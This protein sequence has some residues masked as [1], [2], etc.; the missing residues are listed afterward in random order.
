VY[1]ALFN[2][3]SNGMIPV[4]LVFLV[5]DAG[6]TP[7]ELGLVLALATVG[8][9]AGGMLSARVSALLGTGRAVA[10]CAV[11]VAA[12][13]LLLAATPASRF[14]GPWVVV[15]M[16]VMWA[17]N[18]AWNA[19]VATLRQLLSPPAILGRLTAAYRLL[20]Y[21]LIPVGALTGGILGDRIGSRS[22]LVVLAG[23]IAVVTLLPL[24]RCV[25]ELRDPAQDEPAE[26]DDE[27]L[28]HPEPGQSLV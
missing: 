6:L 25:R 20:A 2:G 23:L 10:A 21:V 12:G 15:V 24:G 1:T 11:V 13:E 14:A 19:Q 26:R 18:T 3:A 8:A 16:G 27:P 28:V 9:I 5:R 17:A 7:A 4:L 22:A